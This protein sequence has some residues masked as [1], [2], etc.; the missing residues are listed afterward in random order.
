MTQTEIVVRLSVEGFHHWPEAKELLPE[1]GFLS[2]RHRH[3]FFI[4]VKKVVSHDDRDI[5]IIL[6]KRAIIKHLQE[7]YGFPCEFGRMS[8]E[9]IAREILEAFACSS[10]SVLEDNENGAVITNH[11]E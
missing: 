9:E 1:A 7:A 6:F 8:C 4:E 2:D 11:Y 3:M 5:E 10:V